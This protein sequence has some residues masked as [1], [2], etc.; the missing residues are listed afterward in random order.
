MPKTKKSD[1]NKLQ[2]TSLFI[3]DPGGIRTHDPQLRRLLLYP[4]ELLD[5]KRSAKVTRITN[6]TT[7]QKEF[8]PGEAPFFLSHP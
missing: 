1:C 6:L 7:H 3:G 2:R 8:Q 4:T 5:Q